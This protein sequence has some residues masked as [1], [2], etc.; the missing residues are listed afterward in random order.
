MNHSVDTGLLRYV[1]INYGLVRFLVQHPWE[2]RRLPRWF[3]QRRLSPLSMR[4]PWWPYD[5]V[6]WVAEQLPLGAR[7]FE[8]GGGGSTLWLEDR[9]AIV[10]VVD[11][12]DVWFR[13]LNEAVMASTRVMH[14][15]S[16]P[17][18]KITSDVDPGF[19]D[20]YVAA[21]NSEFDDSLDLV[22]VDGRARVECVRKAMRKV[23]PGG[24]LL[25]D[26]TD[27]RKYTP[28]LVLLAKWE[29]HVFV[30][31]KPGDLFPAQTSVWRRPG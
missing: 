16:S 13:H 18:G 19:F 26:D 10:T 17:T 12:D 1:K 11:H 27:R 6:A 8:Y 14:R 4:V 9:G 5:A 22:V 28:A 3:P 31:L 29:R 30:G 15:E 20:G 21:I 23:K 2:I 25:L 7:V 24:L